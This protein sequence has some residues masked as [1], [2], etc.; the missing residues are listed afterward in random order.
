MCKLLRLAQD[1][2]AAQ[3]LYRSSSVDGDATHQLPQAEDVGAVLVL[4]LRITKPR[5]VPCLELWPLGRFLHC[6]S[7]HISTHG[8]DKGTWATSACGGWC[9]LAVDIK[10]S[11]YAPR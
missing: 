2:E 6:P 9:A 3:V 10:R 1:E 11:W 7:F 8:A 4:H 5:E